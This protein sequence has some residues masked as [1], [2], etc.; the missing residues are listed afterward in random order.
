MHRS[1]PNPIVIFAWLMGVAAVL[2][3][4]GWDDLSTKRNVTGLLL[5]FLAYATI[6][7]Y[8]RGIFS[9]HFSRAVYV[10][11]FSAMA[12]VYFV[13]NHIKASMI[14]VI[15]AGVVMLACVSTA[16][17]LRVKYPVRVLAKEHIEDHPG[18]MRFFTFE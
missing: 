13:I 17:Y 8:L 1:K 16:I 12:V 2:F 6:T 5:C 15:I 18:W 4:I 7:S 10:C 9:W 3:T 14:T 11:L